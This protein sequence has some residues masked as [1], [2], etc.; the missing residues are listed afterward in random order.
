MLETVVGRW[1][2]RPGRLGAAP[3][4][5]AWPT[6][7]SEESLTGR[8]LARGVRMVALRPLRRSDEIAWRRLRLADDARLRSLDR[9][10]V[11]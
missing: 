1:R 6:T 3:R 2:R 4:R 9:K 5:F 10:S 7:L 11:V 8:G